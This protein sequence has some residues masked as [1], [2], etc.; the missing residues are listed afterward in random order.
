MITQAI[1][2]EWLSYC[3]ETGSFKWKKDPGKRRLAG[4]EFGNKMP[5]GYISGM[6]RGVSIY[7]HRLAFLYM[8]GEIPRYVDHKNMNK[9]DNRWNNL[10]PATKRDNNVH[11]SKRPD[12]K[13]KYKG[14]RKCGK[15]TWSS[16]IKIKDKEIHLGCFPSEKKAAKAYDKKAKELF[17]EFARL[18]FP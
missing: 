2:K 3:P 13:T 8:I 10:R 9:S 11:R 16:R 6:I 5:V 17:G 7:A 15:N 18:N 12:T 14:A 1:V 4:K